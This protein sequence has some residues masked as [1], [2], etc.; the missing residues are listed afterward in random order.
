MSDLQL[1]KEIAIKLI[2]NLFNNKEIDLE[3][4]LALKNFIDD[5]YE[6][7]A[8]DILTSKVTDLKALAGTL[9]VDLET[10]L[11]KR[12]KKT[13]SSATSGK[14]YQNPSNT[15][16]T[17]GGKGKRPRWLVALLEQ[18]ANLDDFAV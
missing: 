5:S 11:S 18:G 9:G 7:S 10:L 1:T 15:T 4:L 6:S 12:V 16:E 13:S 2:D 3:Q 14:T 8:K 17:W